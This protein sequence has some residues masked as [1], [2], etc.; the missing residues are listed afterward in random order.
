MVFILNF[1]WKQANV[2]DLT[3]VAAISLL[4]LHILG[5]A[6][7][8]W[9]V[10]LGFCRARP[11]CKTTD[12]IASSDEFWSLKLKQFTQNAPLKDRKTNLR[13][14]PKTQQ[15]GETA[16]TTIIYHC[17]DYMIQCWWLPTGGSNR[18][19]MTISGSCH[20][21]LKLQ[22]SPAPSIKQTEPMHQNRSW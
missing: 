4:I 15:T 10:L 9:L 11:K 21:R 18:L 13:T 17:G 12:T 5:K 19:L 3:F 16:S 14:K 6:V 2:P 1:F 8:L 22:N 20:T 7:A